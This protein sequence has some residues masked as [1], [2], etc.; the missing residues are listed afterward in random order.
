MTWLKLAS[1][2]I[3]T[4]QDEAEAVQAH[5]FTLSEAECAAFA[6]ESGVHARWLNPEWGHFDNVAAAALTLFEMSTLEGWQ[7]VMWAS[8]DATD[9]GLAPAHDAHPE[10][11]IFFIVWIILGSVLLLNLFVGILVN[12]FAEVKRS[13]EEEGD[14]I[15]LS[16]EQQQWVEAMESMLEMRPRKHAACPKEYAT[17]VAPTLF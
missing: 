9:A 5:L 3:G 14:G 13:E 11:A 7:T 6:A 4:R 10:A 2:I 15:L 1:I 16:E 8:I 17:H 12:I